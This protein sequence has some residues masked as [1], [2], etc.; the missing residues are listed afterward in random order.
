MK[1]KYYKSSGISL[2]IGSLLII[3]TMIIHPTGGDFQT[4]IKTSKIIITTHSIAI[5]CLPFVVFGFL[6]LTT[7]L[8]SEYRVSIFAFISIVQGLISAFFAA[9]FNGLVLPSYLN[10]FSNS[11]EENIVF[12]KPIV[13]FSFAINKALDLIFIVALIIAI[14]LYSMLILRLEKGRNWISYLGFLITFLTLIGIF[15]NLNFQHLL[16]FQIFTISIAIWVLASGILL[17]KSK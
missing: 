6:G 2:I 17:I 11:L 13:S 10:K 3:L 14:F 15:L 5:C 7:K 16:E 4:I 9:L 12:L 1:N 8:S